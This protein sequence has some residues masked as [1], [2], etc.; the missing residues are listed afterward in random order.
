M[1][2]RHRLAGECIDRSP[3]LRGR[4]RH[5]RQPVAVTDP[6]PATP[7]LDLEELAKNLARM[8]EEGGKALAAYMKPR[9]Q[10]HLEG[11]HAE[12]VDAVKALGQVAQYWLQ[13]PQRVAEL[14]LALG[15]SYLDLWASSIRRLAGEPT[16]PV[17]EPDARDKRFS[18]PEWSRNYFF[19]FLK[20][21]YLL[22]A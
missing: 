11:E 15:R 2:P 12:F 22:T 8:V 20:Q 14:Q 18:D 19:D 5:N 13:D 9:E 16:P 1:K 4:S 6:T 10:G 3:Y 21:A 7:S 17:I